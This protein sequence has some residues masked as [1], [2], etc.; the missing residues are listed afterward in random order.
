MPVGEIIA[1]P[2]LA[3]QMYQSGSEPEL[4][5]HTH[6]SVTPTAMQQRAGV[7]Y[8]PSVNHMHQLGKCWSCFTGNSRQ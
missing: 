6:Q 4:A 5:V 3:T 2:E 8:N 1:N 7:D